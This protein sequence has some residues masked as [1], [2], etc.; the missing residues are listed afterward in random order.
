[1]VPVGKTLWVIRYREEKSGRRTE[2]TSRERKTQTID[3]RVVSKGVKARKTSSQEV[4]FQPDANSTI[5]RQAASKNKNGLHTSLI[6]PEPP[7][8]G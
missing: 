5:N 1:M 4:A 3:A 8:V 2:K 7:A 6:F